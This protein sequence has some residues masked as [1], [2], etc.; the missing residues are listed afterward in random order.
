MLCW[1]A[2]T[3]I[4]CL[5]LTGE[6]WKQIILLAHGLQFAVFSERRQIMIVYPAYYSGIP[7]SHTRL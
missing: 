6:Y 5:S 4:H 1:L 7:A 2:E 3:E